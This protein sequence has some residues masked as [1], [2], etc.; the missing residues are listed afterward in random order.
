MASQDE[1]QQQQF[2]NSSEEDR[3]NAILTDLRKN[4]K[5]ELKQM[6]DNDIMG[7]PYGYRFT[8]ENGINKIVIT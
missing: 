2:F 8:K 1:Y 6:F 7:K 3:M 4:N 5:K